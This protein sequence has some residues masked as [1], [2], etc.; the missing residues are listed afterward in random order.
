MRRALGYTVITAAGGLEAIDTYRSRKDAIDMVILDMIM[1]EL[2][3]KATYEALK[4][5]DPHVKALLCS[6]Y[7]V[8]SEVSEI[9]QRGCN[10]FIQK[11]FDLATLS[12]RI[13][14]VLEDS[15]RA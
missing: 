12:F 2:S 4:E 7:S 11:P 3:G 8:N 13:R 5:I 14:E 10:G 6:G 9:L 1:P 15:R